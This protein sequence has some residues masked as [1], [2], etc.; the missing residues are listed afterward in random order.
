[1]SIWEPRYE[2]MPRPELERLQLERLKRQLQSVYE[3]V[4]FYRNSFLKAGITPDD[5]NS[6]DDIAKLP[7]TS[8][9]DVR[10]N[11]P[12]GLLAVPLSQVVRVH[13]SSGTTGK[14][15]VAPYN[16]SDID[17]WSNLMARSLAAAG[18]VS[19]VLNEP[20]PNDSRTLTVLTPI[21]YTA[22]GLALVGSL[23]LFLLGDESP[24]ESE[25]AG[26]Y[27]VVF[28]GGLGLG[29]GGRF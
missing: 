13:A 25:R 17:T 21:G 18:V 19:M 6:L 8:K 20:H 4:P 16:S 24:T 2:Q 14:P 15:I 26:V 10:N 12:L 9:D 27:P 1:M 5:I 22:G 23:I 7:F 28:P 11:Y 3:K 29:L